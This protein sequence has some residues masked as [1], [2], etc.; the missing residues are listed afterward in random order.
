MAFFS[1]CC[2]FLTAAA[3][4][5]VDFDFYPFAKGIIATCGRDPMVKIWTHPTWDL[6]ADQ[7]GADCYLAGHE[8]KIDIIKFN[9]AVAD[10]L[11][12]CSRFV[13]GSFFFCRLSEDQFFF[14]STLFSSNSDLTM[15]LWDFKQMSEIQ[16]IEGFDEVVM[17]AC[18]SPSGNLI[19]S[20]TRDGIVR[21]Y[22]PRHNSKP[23]AVKCPD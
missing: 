2:W 17:S 11:L 22:D 1:F 12:T 15:K 4:Q 18:W 6:I 8:K 9:P 14:L 16:N 10:L 23:A 21:F 3:Q 13:L 20:A 19:L 5:I 7:D